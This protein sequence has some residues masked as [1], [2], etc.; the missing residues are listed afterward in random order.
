MTAMLDA[1]LAYAARGW[2][3]HPCRPGS[4]VPM[5]R[6]RDAATTDPDMIRRWWGQ[7]STANVAIACGAPAPD[8][9]DVDTKAG[10]PGPASFARLRDAALLHGAFMVVTTPSGGWHVYF[11]GTGQGNGALHRHGI[12]FRGRGGFVLAPPSIVDG[13][14]YQLSDWREPTGA[15]VDWAAIRNYLDPPRAQDAP[16]AW[17]RDRSPSDHSHLVAWLELRPAGDRNQALL[18]ACHRALE[19]GADDRVLDELRDAIVRAGH[20]QRDAQRTTDSARRRAGA[21]ATR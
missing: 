18:W 2:P 15:T 20:D 9:V 14:A 16:R 21:G 19:A 17:R 8:V 4:K 13:R 1:A 5:T 3:V 10:A 12:D 11:A 7:I 6:W